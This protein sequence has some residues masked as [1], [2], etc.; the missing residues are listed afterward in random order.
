MRLLVVGAIS[1]VLG[2]ALLAGCGKS[3]TAPA[4]TAPKALSSGIDPANFDNSVRAQDDF[5]RHVDGTWLKKTEIP[6]DKSNYGAFT[7][8][9][10]DAEQHL[11]EII[12]AANNKKDKK[13]GSDDQKVG[14]L[15]APFMD[16]KKADALGQFGRASCRERVC[17][18]V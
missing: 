15:Y 18:Y 17:Q 6:A 9:A 8:L 7:K 14:D 2:T 4:A 3:Q 5:Y 11:R 16:Q 12:E 10:D 1:A 13:D